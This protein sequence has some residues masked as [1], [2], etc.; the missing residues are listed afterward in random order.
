MTDTGKLIHDIHTAL[1]ALEN[2]KPDWMDLLDI[3]RRAAILSNR[4][5]NRELRERAA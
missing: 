1:D 2:M 3:S 5:Y 4:E